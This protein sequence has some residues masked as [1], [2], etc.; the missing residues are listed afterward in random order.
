[1][2]SCLENLNPL[3]KIKILRK[4]EKHTRVI[5]REKRD[6]IILVEICVKP[7][8]ERISIFFFC[9]VNAYVIVVVFT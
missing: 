2:Y 7:S 6:F 8:K 1:M 9:L 4:Y 3:T 5:E